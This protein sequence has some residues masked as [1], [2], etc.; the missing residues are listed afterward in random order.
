MKDFF[1]LPLKTLKA[2][3][4]IF[5][6]ILVLLIFIYNIKRKSFFYMNFFEILTLIFAFVFGYLYVENSK[7]NTDI[8]NEVTRILYKILEELPKLKEIDDK[9]Y[10]LIQRKIN[11]YIEMISKVQLNKDISS[12]IFYIKMQFEY[13]KYDYSIYIDKMKDKSEIKN[14][15]NLSVNNIETKVDNIIFELNCPIKKY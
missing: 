4:Y 7:R 2:L 8:K 6:F 13:I 3:L 15:I 5:L 14:H 10:T 9:D 12:D 11:N 1:K